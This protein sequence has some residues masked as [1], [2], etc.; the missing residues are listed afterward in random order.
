[1]LTIPVIGFAHPVVVG[2]QPEIDHGNVVNYGHDEGCWPGQGCTVWLAGH[3]TSHGGVFR[4]VPQL[5]AG[6][7]LALHYDGSTVVYVVTDTALVSRID[8]PPGV[9]HGDLMIQ[10]SW[11][12]GRVLLVYA[13]RSAI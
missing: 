6:D 7:E 12:E 1:M 4:K 11:T 5:K 9:L 3:R 13:D 8:P 2:D 10:T